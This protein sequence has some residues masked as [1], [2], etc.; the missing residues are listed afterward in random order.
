MAVHTHRPCGTPNAARRPHGTPRS[1]PRSVKRPAGQPLDDARQTR[2]IARGEQEPGGPVL[3]QFRYSADP[4]ADQPQTV[5]RRF[6]HRDRRI[7]VPQRRDQQII[8]L[9]EQCVLLL[10][11]HEPQ[12]ADAR[13]LAAAACRAVSS[14]GPRPAITNST[15]SDAGKRRIASSTTC[16]PFSTVSRQSSSSR[17]VPC[18]PGGA[19]P[20][21][22]AEECH[23]APAQL[24]GTGMPASRCLSSRNCRRADE[25]IDRAAVRQMPAAI[26]RGRPCWGACTASSRA[27]AGRHA[28]RSGGNRAR[29]APPAPLPAAHAAR[30]TRRIRQSRACAPH[31]ADALQD[32]A[33]TP[34]R[35]R[36]FH[37]SRRCHSARLMRGWP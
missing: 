33:K 25:Q 1:K 3:H 17:S 27:S 35:R 23:S 14:S 11:L 20:E 37:A 6:H 4:A 16:T 8:R 12:E 19:L 9:R 32:R 21:P 18:R 36:R 29:C 24:R 31:P 22:A 30:S 28:G 2:R 13:I 7:L 34:R 26:G 15:S 10:A 5:R